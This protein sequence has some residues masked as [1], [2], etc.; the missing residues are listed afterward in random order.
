M[1][2]S[3]EDL[4]S[5]TAAALAEVTAAEEALGI[6]LRELRAGSRAEKVTIT[7]VIE[8]AFSRLRVARFEL[9]KLQDLI[10]AADE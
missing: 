1:K 10:A 2:A 4:K 6:A 5:R 7:T 8:D 9:A 3:I